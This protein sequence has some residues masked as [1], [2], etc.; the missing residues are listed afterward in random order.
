MPSSCYQRLQVCERLHQ[1][2]QRPRR[3]AVRTTNRTMRDLETCSSWTVPLGDALF[4]R[5]PGRVSERIPKE[6]WWNQDSCLRER[7][8]PPASAS[9]SSPLVLARRGRP[10]P[11]MSPATAPPR[12]PPPLGSSPPPAS[13]STRFPPSH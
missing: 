3:A 6:T 10:C 11:P 5:Q 7:A 8:G 4:R 1:R 2:L 9:P 13:P 12:W